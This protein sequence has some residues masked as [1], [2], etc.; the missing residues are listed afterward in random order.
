MSP[1]SLMQALL[2]NGNTLDHE[3]M[4]KRR[5]SSKLTSRYT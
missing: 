3:D 5:Y 1:Y 4:S 2:I